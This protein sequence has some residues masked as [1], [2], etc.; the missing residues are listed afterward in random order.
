MSS[1]VKT[2]INIFGYGC[3]HGN[4]VVYAPVYYTTA[5]EMKRRNREKLLYP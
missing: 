1:K 5:P 3:L 2:A 4:P